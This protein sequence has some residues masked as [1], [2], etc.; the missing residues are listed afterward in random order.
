[1]LLAPLGL[2]VLAVLGQAAALA[3]GGNLPRA[4]AAIPLIVL[5]H[6]LYGLGFWRGLFTALKPASARPQIPVALETIRM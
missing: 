1:V 5:T 4:I 6:I 2:Y 3:R